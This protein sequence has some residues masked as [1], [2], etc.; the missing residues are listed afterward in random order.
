MRVYIVFVAVTMILLAGVVRAGDALPDELSGQRLTVHFDDKTHSSGTLKFKDQTYP[1]TG[2]F[3]DKTLVGS[4]KAGGASY[5]FTITQ[6]GQSFTFETQGTKYALKGVAKNA[7]GA[8]G[9]LPAKP[10]VV[11]P[12]TVALEPQTMI[13]PAS[14]LEVATLL[15]PSGWTL[16][17]DVLWRPTMAQFVCA[18]SA[19]FDRKS[20]WGLRWLPMDRFNASPALFNE[21][22][23]QNNHPMSGGL[24]LCDAVLSPADYVQQVVVPRYRKING[25]KIV[26]TQDLKDVTQQI[27]EAKTDERNNARQNGYEMH[28]PAA[29]VRIEYPGPGDVMMQ[30][31]IYCVLTVTWNPQANANVRNAGFPG[32]QSFLFYPDRLYSFSAP[33]GQLDAATPLLQTILSSMRETLK[34]DAY[35]SNIN[36]MMQ[37]AAIDDHM[38]EMAARAQIT[39]IQKKTFEARQKSQDKIAGQVGHLIRGTQAFNNP[40]PNKPPIVVPAGTKA[41]IDPTGKVIYSA[42]SQ[43]NPAT[44]PDNNST[45]TQL[46][47]EP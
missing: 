25:V 26:E 3:Q 9:N 38:M 32:T 43:Y 15:V 6:D 36:Q 18:T 7:L 28:Y 11:A 44:A 24:E 14:K 2:A 12:R 40:N 23:K 17:S 27:E 35:I 22:R 8:G 41:W 10:P 29:R 31:D 20:G 13:D 37:R 34:W 42:D 21:A 39:E 46:K 47:N 45:W 16:K 19:V 33:K 4:F 1:F 30:E 5:P